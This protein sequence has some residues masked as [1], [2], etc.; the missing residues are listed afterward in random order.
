MTNLF[1]VGLTGSTGAGKSEVARMMAE[2][3]SWIVIDADVLSRRV[4][5]PGQPALKELTERFSSDILHSDGTLN[6]KRLA[7]KAFSSQEK[8]EALNA[9]VH[10]A[11]RSEIQRELTEA[12]EQGKA[13]AVI[14]APLLLQAGLDAICDYTLAVVSTPQLRQSR[15]LERDGLTVEEAR[16]RMSAQP[17]DDYY[18]TRVTAV[19]YNLGERDSLIRAAQTVC[20]TIEG[21]VV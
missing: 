13:V 16:R 12:A 18:E 1:I 7:E 2:R 14:D 8:T 17:S 21:L 19:L 5:E 4:V 20:E 9:I 3:P 10:P 15:I 6:R 11:V